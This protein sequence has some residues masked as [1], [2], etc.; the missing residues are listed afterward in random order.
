MLATAHTLALV[1]LEAHAV[2][3]EV[4]S[5][6]GTASFDVVGLPETTVRE[7]RV[8]VRAA[9]ERVGVLLHSH[10]L[11]VNLA[12]ADLRK[13]GSAFDL[14]IAIAVLGAVGALPE[15][16][17]SDIHFLGELSLTGA[18]RPVRGLLPRL[19]AARDRGVRLVVVPRANEGEAAAL[20]DGTLE[21]RTAC[22]LGEVLAHLRGEEPLPAPRRPASPRPTLGDDLAEVQGQPLARRAL[23][24][25]AAG[26]H[27]LLMLGPPGAGK[28]M[29]ARRLPSLL[30]PLS[31][32][33]ALVV[34]AIHSVAGILPEGVGLVRERP[35]R[36]P[37][38][39]VSDAG[40]LGGGDPA[41]PGEISLA[42]AG[43]LFLDE[44]PEFRRNVIEGLRQPLEDGTISVVRAS[45]SA[46]FPA[47]PLLVAAMNP[48]PCGKHPTNSCV[49]TPDRVRQYRGRVSGPLLDRI[50][51]QLVLPRVEVAALAAVTPTGESSAVVRDRVLKA[52][53]V[54]AARRMCGEVEVSTN[55]RLS[56][57]SLQR[58]AGLD[59]TARAELAAAAQRL[60]LSARAYGRL[61]RVAR[62]LAD[63][64]G[65]DAVHARHVNEAVH[66]RHLDPGRDAAA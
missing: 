60:D 55:A 31:D 35:F 4:Q 13:N 15:E 29:L 42:H 50:D 56:A 36:A 52:R 49:C 7:S 41:R 10:C 44:F 14:A 61:Q 43:V 39:S 45:W 62:T 40:L 28:T 54:Q 5:G 20:G 24:V 21:V 64:E 22:D 9:L 30:P 3:V 25:A 47:R 12:P 26:G 6:R 2:R 57:R 1:G 37:H 63:L 34:T 48:C 18:L 46:V 51:L 11:T 19:L 17:F 16:S 8:R 65:T 33:E 66:F 23:E 38:H 53:E 27:D 59:A 58:V 32:E